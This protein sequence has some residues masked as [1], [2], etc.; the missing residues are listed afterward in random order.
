MKIRS[1]CHLSNF[2]CGCLFPDL[3]TEEHQES[4]SKQN[5]SGLLINEQQRYASL[6]SGGSSSSSMQ[7]VSSSYFKLML[8]FYNLIRMNRL[9]FHPTDL[10]K[11]GNAM[12]S[13]TPR[14]IIILLTNYPSNCLINSPNN[15]NKKGKNLRAFNFFINCG[16]GFD[17]LK[18]NQSKTQA[19][20][21]QEHQLWQYV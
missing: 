18:A 6:G 4:Y 17:S 9:I 7:I 5:D 1:H 21:T 10:H 3:S 13:F 16:N 20:E 8:I 12:P 2:S 11:T 14:K 15:K 19:H